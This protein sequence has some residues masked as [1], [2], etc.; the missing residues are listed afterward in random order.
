MQKSNVY[1]GCEGANFK[2]FSNSTF[3]PIESQYFAPR[4]CRLMPT[5][6]SLGPR[7]ILQASEKKGQTFDGVR[8]TRDG[9]CTPLNQYVARYVVIKKNKETSL[10]GEQPGRNRQRPKTVQ[11]PPA[12]RSDFMASPACVNDS[13]K[14]EEPEGKSQ[15]TRFLQHQLSP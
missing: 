10:R 6:V 8:T 3:R 4:C 5:S 11:D 7:L 2:R 15:L 12:R 14:T 1:A 9:I 13:Q